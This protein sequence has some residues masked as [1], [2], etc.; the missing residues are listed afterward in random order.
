MAESKPIFVVDIDGVAC[1]HAKAICEWVSHE[2]NIAVTVDDVTSWD[3]NFGPITF[4]KAVNTC[5]PNEKFILKMEVTPG[6]DSF[7]KQLLQKAI[8]K[9]ATARKK[10]AHEATR[11][12]VNKNFGEFETFFV[13]SKAEL[14][15]DFIVDDYLGEVIEA[16]N[17]GKTSFLFS[18]PWNNNENTKNTIVKL[19]S[20]H[21]V[22][23]FDEII[24]ILEKEENHNKLW[25]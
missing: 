7:L 3:P 6:F 14:S 11:L 5:Y 13:K 15:C 12:W 10:Y 23:S 4:V 22:S 18:R 17:T 9:F 19:S 25:G 1:E 24:D 16:A 21:F 8:V 20:C 2:Y